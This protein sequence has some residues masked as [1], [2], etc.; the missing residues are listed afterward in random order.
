MDAVIFRKF[1]YENFLASLLMPQ[2]CRTSVFA[3]RALNIEL[4]QIQD[5]VSEKQIGLMRL[6]FWRDAL[7]RIFKG[8]PPESPIAQQLAKAVERHNLS[9]HWFMQ[10]LEC[11]EMRLDRK[12]EFSR[13][14]EIEEYADKSVCSLNYLMLEC[15]GV[16]NVD[17]DHA[18]SHLGKAQGIVTLIRGT[19]H[20]LRSN[21]VSLPMELLLMHNVSQ[22]E[23]IRGCREQKM[24]DVI[25]DLAA[26]ANTH[27]ETA[28]SIADKVPRDALPAFAVS[29]P[30]DS[31]LKAL[32]RADF[33]IFDGRLQQRNA[34]LPLLMWK[35]KYQRKY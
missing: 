4:A 18:I 8:Q 28:R 26:F 22:E 32:Q 14:K 19:V 31:Y 25:Y 34:W 1:D 35:Q 21:Q 9:L 29:V 11:R 16:R 6:Q 15:L 7:L 3:I 24:K 27:L 12:G 30:T 13:M 23:V 10:L 33:D 5:V 2:S 17:A 20:N